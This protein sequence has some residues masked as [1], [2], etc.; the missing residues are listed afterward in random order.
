[1]DDSEQIQSLIRHLGISRNQI[2]TR[3]VDGEI[4]VVELYLSEMR[5][6]EIPSSLKLRL[7]YLEKIDLQ[8][9]DL[10]T[11]PDHFFAKMPNLKE[12]NLSR[13]RLECIP[14]QLFWNNRELEKLFLGENRIRQIE[15]GTFNHLRNLRIL[16]LHRN[17]LNEIRSNLV[18]T[19]DLDILDLSNN[20]ISSIP[21]GF[22]QGMEVA[23][24]NLRGNRLF[25]FDLMQLPLSLVELNLSENNLVTL[26]IGSK[27]ELYSLKK[28]DLSGNELTEV[29]SNLINLCPNLEEINLEDNPIDF[30]FRKKI[31]IK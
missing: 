19:L 13:N 24:L 21:D 10:N 7:P 29:P 2:V 20:E 18:K 11:V 1:M 27:K 31:R 15:E 28:L 23:R 22:F 3:Q 17:A 8:L 4:R 14:K 6:V 26:K 30:S 16:D 12:V 9:N 25:S 5:L